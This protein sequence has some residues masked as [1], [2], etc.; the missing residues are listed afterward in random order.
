M[1]HIVAKSAKQQIM[2]TEADARELAVVNAFLGG[3]DTAFL[4]LYSRYEAPLLVYCRKM[5]NDGRTAEDSFQE[6]WLRIYELRQRTIE[7]QHF[8][9]LLFRTARNVCYNRLRKEEVRSRGTVPLDEDTHFTMQVDETEQDEVR[10]LVTRA[11][12]KLPVEQRE[13]FILHEYSGFGYTDISQILGRSESS[14]KMQAFRAR[15][16]LRQLVAGWL[17][18][19]S[20][21]DPMHHY[22]LK[23]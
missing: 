10:G 3:D 23:K 1:A 15:M 9:S 4:R 11:L 6:T 8:Q 21:D 22:P 7:V 2:Q 17:G 18:L 12:G 5:C 14:V 19:T 13:V 16:R 20:D